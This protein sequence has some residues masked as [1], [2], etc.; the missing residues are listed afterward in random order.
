MFIRSE[1]FIEIGGFDEEIK[2]AEDYHLSKKIKRNKFGRT[3]NV[4][5]TSPRRFENKGV[6][7]M[8]SLMLGSFFN[9]KNKLWF[10][11]DKNYW[12]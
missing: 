11:E 2:V 10:T 1:T 9:R 4:V 12:K 6:F 8:L 3:N 5:F 7:Y